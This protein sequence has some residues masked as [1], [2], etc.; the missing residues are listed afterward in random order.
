MTDDR[1]RRAGSR[2]LDLVLFGATGYTGRLV[3]EVLAQKRPRLAWALAGRDRAKLE[4]VRAE[5]AAAYP[6]LVEPPILV[7]D[8][9]D[10]TAVGAIAARTRVVCTTVGPFSRYGSALVAACAEH[11]VDYCDS[12]GET[13]WVRAMIDAHHARAAATGARIVPCCGFDSI[14]SDLGV[15]ALHDELVA[16]G[17][18]LAEAHYRV[19][20]MSGGMSGGTAASVLAI[21]EQAR[22]PK[23]RRVL[24]DPYALDPPGAPRGPDRGD[25]MGPRRDADTGRWTGPFMMAAVNTRVVRR[26]NALTDFA[27]GRDF[28]YD[29][30]IDTGRGAAGLARA[31]AMTAG[32]GM[33]V[34]AAAT[35]PGRKLVERLVPAPGQGPSAE[36]RE[37]GSFRIE[38]RGVSTGGARLRAIVAGQRDP[39]YGETAHMLAE[40]ALCLAED[41]L[42]ARGGLLTPASCMGMK[43]VERLRAAG[44]TIRV[45]AASEVA[46]AGA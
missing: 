22:D 23:V 46:P 39:G 42:P 21:L 10:A 31:A 33:L 37:H 8:A 15:L 1:S 35:G 28:R 12:T 18:R 26:T 2:D 6:G 25:S 45:E 41:E 27:Y 19:R 7:A 20:H 14:P 43:L 16:R 4:R 24:A 29:E 5:L 40:S 32:L 38:I 44:M 13:P 17:D 36:A 3:A 30:A 11:G 34:A 9:L